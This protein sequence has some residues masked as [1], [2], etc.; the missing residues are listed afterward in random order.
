MFQQGATSISQLFMGTIYRVPEYQRAYSWTEKQLND[1]WEDLQSLSGF[2]E[3]GSKHFMGTLILEPTQEGSIHKYGKYFRVF[4]V[5]DGQQRLT[6]IVVLMS[7]ICKLLWSDTQFGM[8]AENLYDQFIAYCKNRVPDRVLQKLILGKEDSDYFWDVILDPEPLDIDPK[9]P[10]QRRLRYAKQFFDS[11]L[12]QFSKEDLVKYADEIQSRVLLLTYQ[13]GSDLEAGLIFE[14]INDRGKNLSQLDKV[15]SYLMYVA[16]KTSSEGLS[17]TINAHWGNLLRN[18]AEVDPAK[19]D[20]EPEENS[21]MRYHWIMENGDYRAYQIHRE[22][23]KKYSL[24]Q[25][26]VATNAEQYVKNLAET[27]EHYL[28]IL[29]PDK[30][31]LFPFAD[32]SVREEINYYVTCLNRLGAVANFIPLLIAAL[33]RFPNEPEIFK[34][35][36]KY[37]YLLAWRA[38]RVCGRRSDTGI[39]VL[40]RLACDLLDDPDMFIEVNDSLKSLETEYAWDSLFEYNLRENTLSQYERKF[41]LCEW[42]AYLSKMTRQPAIDW[43]RLEELQVEHIWARQPIGFDSW[44]DE[45]KEKH[46]SL[47]NKLGNLALVS[48]PWNPQLSNRPL[49]EK[50]EKYRTANLQHLRELPKDDHFRKVCALEKNQAQPIEVL[51]AVEEFVQ[52]RTDMLVKFALDRWKV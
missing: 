2:I 45:L 1:L 36:A 25:A 48:P 17:A 50:E 43:E 31:T 42:E 26:D 47:V 20:T 16:S 8:V 27:S 13:V 14:T 41:L 33:G 39:S 34:E 35:I 24:T 3:N 21:L 6:S 19:D 9:T 32:K 22:V 5:I 40:S 52:N 51:K 4:H 29:R 30:A 7:C 10:G 11:K 18:I 12:Q 28:K 44:P 38:Y 15:K 23:K 37:C 49:L 46:N